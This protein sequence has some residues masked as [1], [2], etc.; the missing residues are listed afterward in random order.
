MFL[1][2][3]VSAKHNTKSSSIDLLNGRIVEKH[4]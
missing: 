1:H 4:K 2:D 3:T